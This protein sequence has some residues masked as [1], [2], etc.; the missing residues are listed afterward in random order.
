LKALN[1]STSSHFVKLLATYKF[2]EHYYFIFPWADGTLRSLWHRV[3]EPRLIPDQEKNFLWVVK[4]CKDIANALHAIHEYEEDGIKQYGRHGD[5]KPQNILW[6]N[7]EESGDPVTTSNGVLAIAD[8]GLTRF[9]KE[10]SRSN[11]DP[12]SIAGSPTYR[13]PE[14]DLRLPV[15]RAYDIWSLGCVYLEFITWLIHGWQGVENFE[16]ARSVDIGGTRD[17]KFFT[18]LGYTPR[19][20]RA[21]VLRPSVTRWI[22]Q[23][24]ENS[25]S[26]SYI[27]DFLTLVQYSMLVPDPKRRMRAKDVVAE[28]SK[29]LERSQSD[30]GYISLRGHGHNS[31]NSDP[32]DDPRKRRLR[33]AQGR[34]QDC[35]DQRQ[36]RSM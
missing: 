10:D 17:F 27:K 25:S 23:L 28:L 5:I 18:I 4:Q 3:R 22:E 35:K 21:A 20:R 26:T 31:K 36:D 15:S 2:K 13:P 32:T 33:T 19:N 34:D 24:R 9:H 29:I 8:F 6:F 12:A 11:V 30:A 16:R 7:G 14:C 1:S